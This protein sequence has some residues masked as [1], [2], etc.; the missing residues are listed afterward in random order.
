MI[1]KPAPNYERLYNFIFK[2]SRIEKYSTIV[3]VDF[4]KPWWRVMTTQKTRLGIVIFGECYKK[5]IITL[6][7]VGLSYIFSSQRLD[8]LLWFGVM[9]AIGLFLEYKAEFY[10]AV[11]QLQC[12][13]SVH[14]YAHQTLLRIDPIFHTTRSTGKILAKIDRAVN[15]YKEVVEL[16]IQ[17]I[18]YTA[19]GVVTAAISFFAV[20]I[21]LG[22]LATILLAILTI[23]SSLL[24]VLNTEVFI[25]LSIRAEDKLKNVSVENLSQVKLIRSTFATNEAS[26]RLRLYTKNV[27]M[28]DATGWSAFYLINSA[29]KTLYI[30]TFFVLAFATFGLISKGVVGLVMGTALLM[31]FFR[32]TSDVI[33]VGKFLYWYLASIKQIKDLYKFLSKF[34]QQTYPVLESEIQQ[35]IEVAKTGSTVIS[36]QGLQFKYGSSVQIFDN[37]NLFLAVSQEQ[38]NK[39]YGIIGPSGLGKTTLISVLGGQLKPQR[40]TISINGI[41]VYSVDD[42]VRRNILAIQNQTSSSLSGSVG[43]NLVFGL[44]TSHRI[45]SD[46]QLVD[47]LI[48]VGLWK[49]LQEKDGL[50]TQ[51][52]EG[53]L[54]LSGGQRQRLNFASL[55]LRAHYYKP[56]LILIDE[57]T[58][59]LDDISERAITDMIKELANQSTVFVIAHRLNTLKDSTGTLDVSLLAQSKDLIF[60]SSEELAKKSPYY[61]SL[62]S[63]KVELEA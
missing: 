48:R 36:A 26:D 13:Q 25:P 38:K 9:S 23:L 22:T 55:Y 57:P 4:T 60:Y 43:N 27:L 15:A 45:Y 42:E 58:S 28:V 59:S 10:S 32:G 7:P 53:G 31:S 6:T 56:A 63:G 11:L 40:G 41:D 19:V 39:L 49:F 2:F 33:K 29:L 50:E 35:K 14:F 1:Q 52:G 30:A 61:R 3:P 12:A 44:P 5:I 8:Y 20:D 21:Y 37:H 54:T 47:V 16:G 24:F 18:F 34:G 51:V 62:I 46:Q 17:E